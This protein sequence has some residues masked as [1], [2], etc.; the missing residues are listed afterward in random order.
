[1]NDKKLNLTIE[2]SIQRIKDL[3][4]CCMDAPWDWIFIWETRDCKRSEK[5]PWK[6]L[7]RPEYYVIRDRYTDKDHKLDRL[8]IENG[9]KVMMAKYPR[10][11]GNWVAENDDSETGNVFLQ[12]CV[13]GD[14]VYC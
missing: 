6:P 2:F 9:L 14:L 13:F 12:C 3:I 5:L 10:H 7:D 11:F 8:S 4:I 1:M